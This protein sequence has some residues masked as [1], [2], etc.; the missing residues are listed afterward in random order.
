MQR[1]P[2]LEPHSLRNKVGN[3]L[4]T[5]LEGPEDRQ[6][7]WGPQDDSV[8]QVASMIRFLGVGGGCSFWGVYIDF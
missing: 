5:F 8:S 1:F 6:C 4:A 3:L 2:L 7:A